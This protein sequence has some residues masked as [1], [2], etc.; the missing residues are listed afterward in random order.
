MIS[1]RRISEG[2]VD[3]PGELVGNDTLFEVGVDPPIPN[4][5]KPLPN[6]SFV[7]WAIGP[8]NMYLNFSDPTVLNLRNTQWNPDYVVIPKDYPEDS[9]I[10]M[11]IY[12][13]LTSVPSFGRAT[14]PAAHPVL[15]TLLILAQNNQ[16]SNKLQIHLHGHDFALLQ[17][18][19]QAY[20]ESLLNPLYENPPRRDVV[21]LPANGFIAIAF[22]ADNPGSWL[23]HCHIAMHASSGL[24]MQILERQED[25]AGILTPERLKP[26]RDGCQ[27]WDKWSSNPNNLW[28]KNITIFQDDSGI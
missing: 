13:N 12:T 24:A 7:R 22:K 6:D 4:Q 21:L 8:K 15:P 23:L 27:K 16:R 25:A 2:H 26:V 19:A 14:V 20:N 3:G 17:Q 11:V 18:S 28:A 10:Y 5:G 1:P 9:W